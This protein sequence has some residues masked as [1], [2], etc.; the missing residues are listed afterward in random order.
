M[1][2]SFSVCGRAP[3]VRRFTLIELLV[4]IAIIAILAAMLLPALQQARERAKLMTCTNNLKSCGMFAHNYATDNND[5]ASFAYRNSNGAAAYSGY[6]PRDIGT[7]PVLLGPYAGYNKYD[8]YR[9]SQSKTSIVP[10]GKPGPF[11]CAG[12]Q[13]RQG[14]INAYGVKR[15]YAISIQAAGNVAKGHP[16]GYPTYQLKWSKIKQPGRRAWV[17]D[18]RQAGSINGGGFINLNPGV[19]FEGAAWSH[20]NGRSVPVQHVDG[21]VGIYSMGQIGK[22]HTNS[23][24]TPF[25]QGLCYSPI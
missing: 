9:L 17:L 1:K 16:T 7:W 25:T 19:N 10:Y 20:S 8:F 22:F 14:E 23:P 6:A 4:V 2:G 3:A 15:D 12:W 13:P 21:H 5:W 24:W 11:S 18:T